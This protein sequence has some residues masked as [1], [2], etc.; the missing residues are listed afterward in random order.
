[1]ENCS[2][3]FFLLILAEDCF[4]EFIHLLDIFSGRIFGNPLTLL[5]WK[6][7]FTVC[8][9]FSLIRRNSNEFFRV[10]LNLKIARSTLYYSNNYDNLIIFSL[11]FLEEDRSFFLV[12]IL[13]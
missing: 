3:I 12:S 1:M 9:N 2:N 6:F 4:A 5:L 10:E 11:Y 7:H 8:I 13:L